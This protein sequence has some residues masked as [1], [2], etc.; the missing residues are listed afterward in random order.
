MN[1]NP[2]RPGPTTSEPWRM[3]EARVA[4]DPENQVAI[5]DV[6][7]CCGKLGRL[8]GSMSHKKHCFLD[9]G[10]AILRER[11]Q[12]G[13]ADRAPE[14]FHRRLR[15][16]AR[17]DDRT[18]RGKKSRP[19]RKSSH[20]PVA[21]GQAKVQEQARSATGLKIQSPK[22]GSRT[23][24]PSCHLAILPSPRL[25]DFA[26]LRDTKKIRCASGSGAHDFC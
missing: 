13:K 3:C 18:S 6:V 8:A 7:I 4:K 23:C 26:A 5:Q 21:P 14:A 10:L 17:P 2:R 1:R 11:E 16:A 12:A 9:R 25:R 24:R 20:R 15:K 19:R 22:S